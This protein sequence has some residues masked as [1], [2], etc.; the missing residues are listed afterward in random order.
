VLQR[1]TGRLRRPAG[2]RG[3][4]RLG[5]GR[6]RSARVGLLAAFSVAG[7]TLAFAAAP[8]A[9][10]DESG[11]PV[12][13][14]VGI[15]NEVDSFNPFL[16]IEIPSFEM[17]A[18]AY[19]TLTGYSMEDLSPAAT[20]LA[21]SWESSEDGLTW[22]Y[23]LR[24]GVTWSDGEPLTA[25]DA[26]HT[27]ER[28]LDGGPEAA[29]WGS[30]LSGVTTVSAPDDST[31]VLELDKP[32]SGLPSLPIPVLPEHVWSSIGEKDVKTYPNEPADGEPVVGAGPFRLVEGSAGGST[33]R[34]EANQDYWDGAPHIDE[35]VFRVFRSEDPAVAALK[36]GEID[37][38]EGISALQVKALEGT[39]GITAQNGNTTGF[40]EIAFNAGAVD[41]ETGEPMG[42][43]NPAL[44][45][46]AFRYALGFAIDRDQII[47]RVYQGAGLPGSTLIP[48]SYGDRHLE[49]GEDLAFSYDPDR[50]GE[51]LDEAGYVLGDDGLRTMPD[52]SAIGTLRLYARSESPTSL[53]TMNFFKEWLD[54]IGIAAEVTSMESTKLTDVILEGD[55]DAF[56]WG[57]YVDPDPSPMLSYMT[58]D[59]RGNWSDSWYCN[60][61][62]DELYEQQLRE[63]DPDARTE[64]ILQMQEILYRDAPYLITAYNTTGEAFRSD[65]FACLVPQPNPGGVLLYQMGTY[66]YTQ[67]RPAAEAEECSGEAGASAA[68][69]ADESGMGTGALIGIAAAVVVV[70]AGGG[71]VALRRRGTA[72]DRE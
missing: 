5:H 56:Q 44:Q 24:D 66:N 53:D 60:E 12:R 69:E 59:Q 49:P 15:L 25:D 28:I 27:Y 71:F 11:E 68:T 50:A 6:Q 23:Q 18:L 61:E 70:V 42:D 2:V 8:P 45:D 72:G 17:W 38:V 16:G 22:T 62:Y 47:E 65:R 39:P 33:Y 48:P 51:L 46:P 67:M 26:V 34:F 31:V 4:G 19:D 43:G 9:A 64:L 58:C 29:T 3:R 30:Y 32:N 10:A 35:L 13:L 63:I 57:W 21:S 7:S 40:D 37:F 20:G 55:F 52:G 1:A 36:K 41:L 54:D 14:T